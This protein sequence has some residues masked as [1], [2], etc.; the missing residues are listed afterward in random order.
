MTRIQFYLNPREEKEKTKEF[1]EALGL[2]ASIKRKYLKLR[3]SRQTK[4]VSVTPSRICLRARNHKEIMGT[5]TQTIPHQIPFQIKRTDPL[6]NIVIVTPGMEP[7]TL[8][9]LTSGGDA[10]GMN[11]AIWAIT[12]TANKNGSK[13][14][15]IM[16]GFEG[17][18]GGYI[19]EITEEECAPH[20][21]KG[22][23]FLK[24]ARA[25]D[26]R[27]VEGRRKAAEVLRK[28]QVDVLIVIGGDGSMRGAHAIS[29]ECRDLS[30]LFIPG[31]IDHDIP[32]T[33]AIGSATALHRI[34]EAIDCIESTMSSHHRTFVIEVMGRNCGWLALMASLASSASYTLI[35]EDPKK[36]EVWEK[37]LVESISSR[38]KAGKSRCYVILAEG[39]V[40]EEGKK[41]TADRICAL[42][43]E[44]MGI[45]SRSIVLGHTQRGGSPCAYDRVLAPM[46]GVMAAEVALSTPG[47]YGVYIE[48]NEGKIVALENCVKA[49]S[50]LDEHVSVERRGKDFREIYAIVRKRLSPPSE[51]K[52][53]KNIAVAHVGSGS[54]GADEI[55]VAI[56][57]YAR[58]D[59]RNV[60]AV[61]GGLVG[62]IDGKIRCLTEDTAPARERKRAQKQVKNGKWARLEKKWDEKVQFKEEVLGVEANRTFKVSPELVKKALAEIECDLLVLIGGFDALIGAKKLVN[63]GVTVVV[64][65]C[66]VSNNI[67]G[68]DESI[69]SNTALDTITSLCDNLKVG[70]QGKMAFVVEVHGGECGYLTVASGLAMG[71]LDCYFPEETGII[72]RIRR[73][74]LS[75]TK[76]FKKKKSCQLIVRGDGAMRGVCNETLSKILEADGGTKYSVRHCTLGHIQKGNAATAVD[77]VKATRVAAA[78]VDFEKKG[79]WIIGNKSWGVQETSVEDAVEDINEDK[80]RVK[81]ATWLEVARAYRVLG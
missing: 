40:S 8:A 60:Y 27:S 24:S 63:I 45:D 10:P 79:A 39:A 47:A 81:K 21:I 2:Q 11:S 41:I 65:P 67:P 52:R 36:N 29:K 28:H 17:L 55:L 35:P 30:V 54:A 73:T 42:I 4:I 66:T 25:P 72:K 9:I 37:E 32:G 43:N 20:I 1:Y 18:M 64:A 6:G 68:T 15:G 56:A 75:L 59:G 33:E 69:G 16:N 31:S 22:G 44:K 49:C 76:T 26:F 46:L 74:A 70:N 12:K 77:R 61:D 78:C 3:S 5:E 19:R 51:E 38:R 57:E 34:V 48:S 13:V 53:G 58:I 14:L 50:E 62:L 80:R 71:A 7:K 23:T